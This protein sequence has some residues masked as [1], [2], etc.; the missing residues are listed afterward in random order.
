MA[1]AFLGPHVALGGDRGE[2]TGAEDDSAR[3]EGRPFYIQRAYVYIYI[4]GW[5]EEAVGLW[6]ESV[7]G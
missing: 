2:G 3:G 4:H 7:D 5:A 6:V 1:L